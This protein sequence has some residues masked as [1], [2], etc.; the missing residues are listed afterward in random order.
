MHHESGSGGTN[1]HDQAL[2]AELNSGGFHENA[3]PGVGRVLPDGNR[4]FGSDG[5][6]LFHPHAGTTA[7]TSNALDVQDR[8]RA[9]ELEVARADVRRRLGDRSPEPTIR[10][11][12][13]TAPNT[14]AH[15]LSNPN[16]KP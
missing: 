1:A 3:L 13:F 12:D 15:S 11:E 5:A 14:N 2:D 7:S 4:G 10:D 9:R 16:Q 8:I 6:K